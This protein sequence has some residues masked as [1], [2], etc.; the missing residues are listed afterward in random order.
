M[1]IRGLKFTHKGGRGSGHHGHSGGKGGPGNPGGSTP[2]SACVGLMSQTAAWE[3]LPSHRKEEF[4]RTANEIPNAH[5][6][7]LTIVSGDERAEYLTHEGKYGGMYY[8]GS[9]EIAM[10]LAVATPSTLAHEV[11][12]HVE[13]KLTNPQQM[14]NHV[15]Y[16]EAKEFFK[17]DRDGLR[18]TGLRKYSVS[19]SGEFWADSYRIW[20]RAKGGHKRNIEFQREYRETFPEMASLLD[21]TFGGT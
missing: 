6:E 4:I 13:L 7:G 9:K 1:T 14:V 15:G 19:D 3:D 11:G 16:K 8:G 2:D 5:V 21:D 12:H 17:Q 20:L 18:N 10:T